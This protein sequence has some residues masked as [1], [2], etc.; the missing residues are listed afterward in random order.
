MGEAFKAFDSCVSGI[1][2]HQQPPTEMHILKIMTNT[3]HCGQADCTILEDGERSSVNL[4]AY[5][6]LGK[7]L[8][9][10]VKTAETKRR[11]ISSATALHVSSSVTRLV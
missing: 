7:P 11:E 1:S 10:K 6:L 5:D 9:E 2:Q 4:V 3:F 8:L